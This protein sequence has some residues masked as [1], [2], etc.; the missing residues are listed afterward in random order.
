MF[1]PM[2]SWL[3]DANPDRC[4]VDVRTI[5]NRCFFNLPAEC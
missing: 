5:S 4:G 2:L 1:S 3:P